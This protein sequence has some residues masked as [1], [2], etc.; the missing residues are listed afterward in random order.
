MQCA[1]LSAA[2]MS[3]TTLTN[4][5]KRGQKAQRN[6][7]VRITLLCDIKKKSINY[8]TQRSLED[9]DKAY[10]GEHPIASTFVKLKDGCTRAG[11]ANSRG[12]GNTNEFAESNGDNRVVT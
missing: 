8:A 11:Q 1:I 6:Q 4:S 5:G 2:D 12:H 9:I 3:L 7:N 10:A